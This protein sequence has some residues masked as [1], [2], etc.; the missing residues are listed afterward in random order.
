MKIT[1]HCSVAKNERELG[2]ILDVCWGYQHFPIHPTYRELI[3]RRFVE[4]QSFGKIGKDLDVG[5]E[6]AR[7]LYKAA[8]NEM[9]SILLNLW[10]YADVVVP[11]MRQR[12]D[13]E[14]LEF[15]LMAT[16]PLPADKPITWDKHVRVNP[17]FIEMRRKSLMW[18]K[19]F[20][21]RDRQI[22]EANGILTMADLQ[23]CK[24]ADL[25]ALKDLKPDTVDDIFDAMVD[26]INRQ[27]Y[28]GNRYSGFWVR[29]QEN[30]LPIKFGDKLVPPFTH[31]V[32]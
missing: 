23:K 26:F 21:V 14:D 22:L 2:W 3:Q 31:S 30:D 16:E 1:A 8:L 5:A 25:L 11:F 12:M 7:H 13:E 4:K 28:E 27:H 24:W 6:N 20:S 15:E 9:R 19:E 29:T 10:H 18:V 32:N 17:L